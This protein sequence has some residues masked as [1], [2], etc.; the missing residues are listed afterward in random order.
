MLPQYIQLD[1]S[2]APVPI[3]DPADEVITL[4][5]EEGLQTKL[6]KWG[7]LRPLFKAMGWIEEPPA[8]PPVS[9]AVAKRKRGGG[10][11]EPLDE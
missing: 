2:K 8:P 4:Y 1:P 5:P 6:G 10:L 11:L 7:W 9:K 3:I